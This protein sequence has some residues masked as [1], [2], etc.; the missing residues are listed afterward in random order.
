MPEP[1]LPQVNYAGGGCFGRYKQRGDGGS[2]R[3]KIG[4][5]PKTIVNAAGL[6]LL[7]KISVDHVD[8]ILANRIVGGIDNII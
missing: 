1:L 3:R 8:G 4:Y 5:R 6:F 7:V 2:M